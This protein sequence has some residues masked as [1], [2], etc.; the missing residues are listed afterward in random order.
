MSELAS[1]PVLTRAIGVGLALFAALFIEPESRTWLHAAILPLLMALGAYLAA[2]N[3]LVVAA[4]V[5]ALAASASNF[6]GSDIFVSAVYPALAG[7]CAIIVVT[8]LINRLRRRIRDTHE[9]R[10]RARRDAAAEK[11]SPPE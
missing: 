10:W 4:I 5:G 7:L 11:S 8:L 6:G 3:L 2:Q 1:Q 9:E